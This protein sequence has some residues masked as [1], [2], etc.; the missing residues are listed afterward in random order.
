M[1]LFV[2]K[3]LESIICKVIIRKEFE[4][5][6]L[7]LLGIR[8]NCFG[9]GIL[10]ITRYSQLANTAGPALIIFVVIAAFRCY[11]IKFYVM[12]NLLPVGGN[13]WW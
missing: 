10:V 1:K 8:S 11:I 5:I 4:N 7:I 9:T 2:K 3:P 13:N 6:D 12:R